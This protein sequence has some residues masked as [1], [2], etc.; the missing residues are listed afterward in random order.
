MNHHDS[1]S[2]SR[3]YLFRAGAIA[4]T[5]FILYTVVTILIFIFIPGGFPETA[6]DCFEMF[7]NSRLVALVRLDIV[8]V[9]VLP[10]Y[11]ILFYSLFHALKKNHELLARIALFC[12][13]VG[14]TV[15]ISNIN[16]MSIITISDRYNS[17]LSPDYR[18]QLTSACEALLAA[19]MWENTG[20]V[21]SG[22]VTEAGAL[23]FSIIM[24]RTSVFNKVT[25]WISIL[26]HGFDLVSNASGVF[27]PLF[28]EIFTMVA[29][30][31]YVVWFI[32]IGIGL[33]KLATSYKKQS[34]LAVAQF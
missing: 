32:L 20:A 33:N 10:F 3:S 34:S 7:R 2:K 12:T 15:F 4:T 19:N 11:F 16:I 5:L 8:S 28:K 24:L 22:I 1:D 31:L 25:G 9:V 27:N 30:P 6:S 17:A 18:E 21:F 29:G 26:T 14:M 13:V 23:L